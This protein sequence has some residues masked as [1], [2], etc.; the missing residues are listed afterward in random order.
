MSPITS[1]HGA[2]A[3]REITGVYDA[4]P[5]VE[6]AL[7]QCAGN[8]AKRWKIIACPFQGKNPEGVHAAKYGANSIQ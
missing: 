3:L 8:A 4:R 1:W 6:V 7:P 2:K 5:W